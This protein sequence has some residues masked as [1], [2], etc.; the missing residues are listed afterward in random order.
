M[1]DIKNIFINNASKKVVVDQKY[2]AREK[3]IAYYISANSN[4]KSIQIEINKNFRKMKR[5]KTSFYKTIKAFIKTI[6]YLES[7]NKNE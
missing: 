1:N 3:T 5:R 6:N 2:K 4:I 7:R